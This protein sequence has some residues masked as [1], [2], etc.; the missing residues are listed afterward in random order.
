[1]DEFGKDRVMLHVAQC[2]AKKEKIVYEFDKT[3]TGTVEELPPER[4]IGLY[5]IYDAHGYSIKNNA[6][7][8]GS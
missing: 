7:F 3:W 6:S 2:L 1:M 5:G 4:A 8:K